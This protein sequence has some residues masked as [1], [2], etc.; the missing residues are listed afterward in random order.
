MLIRIALGLSELPSPRLVHGQQHQS[1]G[2][3][4]LPAFGELPPMRAFRF[5]PLVLNFLAGPVEF[6]VPKPALIVSIHE[7]HGRLL[8]PVDSRLREQT[9]AKLSVALFEC[10]RPSQPETVDATKQTVCQ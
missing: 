8:P 1:P 10:L 7:S 2:E 6:F 5:G 9:P 4:L 3:G